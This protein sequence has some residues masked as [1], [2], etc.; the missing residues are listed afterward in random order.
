MTHTIPLASHREKAFLKPTGLVS[1]KR[2]NND[3]ASHREKAPHFAG[4]VSQERLE[5]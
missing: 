5:Y 4:L 2:Q 3:P 1:K